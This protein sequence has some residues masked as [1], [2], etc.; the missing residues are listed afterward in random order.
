M[1]SC[2]C[3]TGGSNCSVGLFPIMQNFTSCK[4][5]P[6]VCFLSIGHALQCALCA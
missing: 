1:P 3:G 6:T 4:W 5:T 2:R